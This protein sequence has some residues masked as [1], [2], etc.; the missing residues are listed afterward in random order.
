MSEHFI[1]LHFRGISCHWKNTCC[2]LW[3]GKSCSQWPSLSSL[4]HDPTVTTELW[5]L[6]Q[7]HCV[8]HHKPG[9]RTISP[10]FQFELM[11]NSL[12]LLT[13]GKQ[14]WLFWSICFSTHHTYPSL[15]EP[16]F[17]SDIY[18]FSSWS[19]D[20]WEESLPSEPAIYWLNQGLLKLSFITIT[21]KGCENTGCW[22]PAP[23]ILI[24]EAWGRD[25]GFWQVPWGPCFLNHPSLLIGVFL[26]PSWLGCDMLT[27]FKLFFSEQNPVWV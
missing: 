6:G 16:W 21:W 27:R 14:I 22:T 20:S 2:G 26:F 25:P 1:Y 23:E 9:F 10:V 15:I 17:H 8:C 18:P 24:R 3:Q 19:D 4:A 11:G 7:E 13:A 5:K 12:L